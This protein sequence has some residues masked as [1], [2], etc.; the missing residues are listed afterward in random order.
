MF[1]SSLGCGLLALFG[2][3]E[4]RKLSQEQDLAVFGFSF[5]FTL[6]MAVSNVSLSMVTVPVSSL[7]D[8]RFSR[9]GCF[10]RWIFKLFSKKKIGNSFIKL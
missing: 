10:S 8:S 6:N 4:P 5:L 1:F 3:F 7:A 9:L 2:Y